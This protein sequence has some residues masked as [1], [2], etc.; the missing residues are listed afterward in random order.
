MGYHIETTRVTKTVV[1]GVLSVV[2]SIILVAW[3]TRQGHASV[4]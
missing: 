1:S 4:Q 3:P 2:L